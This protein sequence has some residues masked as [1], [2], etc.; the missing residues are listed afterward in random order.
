MPTPFFQKKIFASSNWPLWVGIALFLKGIQFFTTIFGPHYSDIPGTWAV[1]GGDAISYLQPIE[2]LIQHGAYTPDDRMPGYGVVYLFF[3]LFFDKP[4]AVNCVVVAQYLLDAITVYVLA[5]TALT[6]FKSRFVFYGVFLVALVSFNASV[7]SSLFLTESFSVSATILM[8]YYLV[9]HQVAPKPK[10]LILAGIFFTW[11]IF[12]RPVYLPIGALVVGVWGIQWLLKQRSFTQFFKISLLFLLPFM[13]VD[14]IWMV[15]NYPIHKRFV[16]LAP[17][18]WYASSYESGM[19]NML[20]FFQSFGGGFIAPASKLN[21]FGVS[22][23]LMQTGVYLAGPADPTITLPDDIYTSK[24]SK[25]SLLMLRQDLSLAWSATAD[26]LTKSRYRAVVRNKFAT[27][28]QSIKDEKPFLYYVKAPLR[29]IVLFFDYEN[30]WYSGGLF[31]A[32]NTAPK[33][34]GKLI[35]YLKYATKLLCAAL[36]Y[37][38][39]GLGLIGLLLIL[40]SK[41]WRMDYFVA[42]AAGYSIVIFPVVLRMP[43]PRYFLPA[44]PLMILC[45]VFAV[46]QFTLKI[47]K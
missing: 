1:F 6:L 41:S 26:S 27:Y 25:D 38:V 14:S 32:A 16:P 45:S 31:E 15:R 37:V 46:W 28:T 4:W 5:L 40:R 39:L 43:E 10:Y 30:F 36:Y 22:R 47:K 17:V 35:Y 24:F 21:W 12:L 13:V 2:N 34:S 7:Y 19:V 20:A 33:A 8:L 9:K 29:Y 44:Y 42:L 3:R 11:L 23:I 18:F